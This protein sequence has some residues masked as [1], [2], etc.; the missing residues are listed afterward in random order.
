M[1]I[2][3]RSQRVRYDT[4]GSIHVNPDNP[5]PNS[6]ISKP[7]N[8]SYNPITS[9]TTDLQRFVKFLGTAGGSKFQQNYA[10]LQQSQQEL[11]RNV[12]KA[13]KE[14]GSKADIRTQQP[15]V[16]LQTSRCKSIGYHIG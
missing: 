14:G 5:S 6:L 7:F 16:F 8:F 1:A 2:D 9:R 11:N 12:D 10:I 3:S 13:N 15:K 4:E